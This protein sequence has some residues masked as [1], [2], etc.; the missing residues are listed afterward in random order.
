MNSSKE[1]TYRSYCQYKEAVERGEIRKDSRDDCWNY[2]GVDPRGSRRLTNDQKV[3]SEYAEK[4]KGVDLGCGRIKCHP[5]AIGIDIFPFES[6]DIITDITKLD[7]FKDG[8]LDFVIA[9]HTL[10]HFPDTKAVLR[11]WKR[12]LK[13]DGILGVAVPDGEIRPNNI[14]GS[15]KVVLTKEILR[16]I[17]KWE[18]NMRVIKIMDVPDKKHGKESVIVVAKKR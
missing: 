8:E 18:L 11:E 10:E 16:I 17:F 6:A 2:W 1:K 12:V 13:R 3:L 15:H 7:M 5:N 4:G 9:S 14:R